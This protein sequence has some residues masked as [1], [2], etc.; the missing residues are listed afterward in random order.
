MYQTL[1]FEEEVHGSKPPIFSVDGVRESHVETFSGHKTSRRTILICS[2]ILISLT[3]LLATWMFFTKPHTYT[4]TS[5]NL[6]H[7]S[8]EVDELNQQIET[9]EFTNIRSWHHHHHEKGLRRHRRTVD[10]G[11]PSTTLATDVEPFTYKE[12]RGLNNSEIPYNRTRLPDHLIP[13]EYKL[14]FDI[15]LAKDNFTGQAKIKLQ[16]ETATDKIMFH[17]RRLHPTNI[18]VLSGR[19]LVPI[20]KVT[21][22]KAHEIFVVELKSRLEE[23]S[24]YDMQV[25]FTVGYGGKLAGLYKSLYKDFGQDK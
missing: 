3:G 22:V 7:R 24:V 1:A 6:A 21:Y 8:D 13:E 2:I 10:T 16:C 9:P 15:D 4:S 14:H 11:V 18:T 5:L 12:I 17:G 23:Q 19:T 20:K 25:D